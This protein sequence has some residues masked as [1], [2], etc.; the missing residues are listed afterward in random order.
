MKKLRKALIGASIAFSLAFAAAPATAV[1][2][3]SKTGETSEQSVVNSSESY[4]VIT[5]SDQDGF[6]AVIKNGT[7][8][9]SENG[10]IELYDENGEG[11]GAFNSALLMSDGSLVSI[12]YE[13]NGDAVHAKFSDP[14]E[15]GGPVPVVMQDWVT[16][17]FGTLAT[18]A[19]IAALPLTFG[20]SVVAAGATAGLT[21]YECVQ[22]AQ[23]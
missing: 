1:Q 6:T 10:G 23:G 17:A 11:A 14:I 20:W 18:T 13:V 2:I 9:Q 15:E 21:S 3:D 12:T 8:T 4:I 16:C 5:E 7:F 22:A 19:A